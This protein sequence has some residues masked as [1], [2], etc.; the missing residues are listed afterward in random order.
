M[1]GG[2][3]GRCDDIPL[4]P[5]GSDCESQRNEIKGVRLY[6]VPKYRH[7]TGLKASHSGLE[8]PGAFALTRACVKRCI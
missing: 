8:R 5:M 7:I 3:A 6:A 4:F 1:S 2:L